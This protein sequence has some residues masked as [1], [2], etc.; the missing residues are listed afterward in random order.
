MLGFPERKEEREKEREEKE[1]KE[2]KRK[3]CL[4]LLVPASVSYF[5]F[6]ED[7]SIFFRL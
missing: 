6:M 2:K 1:K 3:I 4:I 7:T 5:A